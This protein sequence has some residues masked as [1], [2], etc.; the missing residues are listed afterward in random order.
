MIRVKSFK[1]IKSGKKKYEI[2]FEKNGKLYTRKFG[3][4]GMSDFTKHKN[5]KRRENYI[6]RHAKDLRTNDP[7]RPGYLSMYILWNKPTLET[8][9]ADY[10]RRLGVYNRTGK[11]PKGITGSKKLAFGA[12]GIPFEDTKM[13]IFPGDIQN[14]IQ[15]DV[16]ASDIQKIQRGRT[17]RSVPGNMMTKKYLKQL[18]LKMNSEHPS[19]DYENPWLILSPGD[20]ETK[21]WLYYAAKILTARDFHRGNLWYSCIEH[22]LDGFVY[23]F[24]DDRRSEEYLEIILANLGHYIDFES[25]DWY[26]R[27]FYWLKEEYGTDNAFGKKKKYPMKRVTK[28]G[29]NQNVVDKM[30]QQMFDQIMRKDDVIEGLTT[31]IEQRCKRG[32]PDSFCQNIFTELVLSI[33]FTIVRKTKY[34]SDNRKQNITEM[35]THLKNFSNNFIPTMLTIKKVHHVKINNL[36]YNLQDHT[37]GTFKNARIAS[38]LYEYIHNIH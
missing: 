8:S 24:R 9:L 7:M 36:A 26:S 38:L 33:Y 1:K 16:S 27:A 12:P 6:S 13:K 32:F 17:T 29:L 21:Q 2:T 22:V 10:K 18:L 11:F 4:K 37:F 15:E 25:P 35:G 28:F 5:R 23:R 31:T 34:I 3:A 20:E 19:G 14:L 30:R